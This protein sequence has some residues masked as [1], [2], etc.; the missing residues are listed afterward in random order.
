MSTNVE[1]AEKLADK[2]FDFLV[3]DY[4]FVKVDGYY[5]SYEYNFGYRKENIEIHLHC[6]ADDG[7]MPFIEL[8]DYNH[9]LA[10]S[11]PTPYALIAIEQ[12]AAVQQIFTNANDREKSRKREFPSMLDH[13]SEYVQLRQSEYNKFGKDEME[14]LIKEN[15][16]IVRRHPEILRG[17]MSCFPKNEPKRLGKTTIAIRQPDG[18]MK[19]TEYINGK[20]AIK[21]GFIG[22]L[23]SV[24]DAK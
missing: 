13:L 9:M 14:I 8:H 23:R 4:G 10:P 5:A 15:A 22:W 6:D 16:E 12:L 24:F 2:Y 3:T 19:V 7:S 18:R 1:D 21:G 17:D 11:R 20:K